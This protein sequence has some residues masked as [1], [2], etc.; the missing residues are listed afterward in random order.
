MTQL[1]DTC[2]ILLF[3]KGLIIFGGSFFKKSDSQKGSGG[4][5]IREG[6]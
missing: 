5:I 4:G 1:D 3:L 2:Q 6:A